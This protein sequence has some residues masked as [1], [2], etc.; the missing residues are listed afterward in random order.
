MSDL[1]EDEEITEAKAADALANDI[2]GLKDINDEDLINLKLDEYAE[3][4]GEEI[5]K[6]LMNA[7]FLDK[8]GQFSPVF[9]ATIL[10]VLIHL[11]KDERFRRL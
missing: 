7:G 10:Q 1:L 4:A 9:R 8:N 3:K 11:E 5:D 2:L 6:A